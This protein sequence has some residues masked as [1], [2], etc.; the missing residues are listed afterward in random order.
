MTVGAYALVRGASAIALRLGISPLIVGLTVVAFG[1]SAPE[2]V[3]SVE[4][5]LKN[6]GGIAVGNVVGSNIANI[7]LILGLAALIRPLTTSAAILKRDGLV[8][9]GA[10][11]IVSGLLLDDQLGRIEGA[12]LLFGFVS[13]IL[14]NVRSAFRSRTTV[15]EKIDEELPSA[16]IYQASLGGVV[17]LL[18]LVFGANLFVNGAV[19]VAETLGVSNAVIGLTVVAIGTSLPELATSLVA[20]VRGESDIAVGNVIGSNTFNLLGILGPA[21][22][23]HPLH[24]PGLHASDLIMMTALGISGVVLLS[25]RASLSRLEGFGLVV[26]YG[27]YAGALALTV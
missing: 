2:F 7:G 17:G 18:M 11:V 20:A 19:E 25:T 4:A 9:I 23:I 21:A 6:A 22:L 10:S 5:A 12:L 27:C 1:T 13:Y 8:M 3:V 26:A 24:A 15:P 16:P 14:W